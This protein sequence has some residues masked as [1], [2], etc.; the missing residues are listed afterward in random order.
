ME[1]RDSS[2]EITFGH[3]AR[4]LKNLYHSFLIRL[5]LLFQFI[6]KRWL[7]LLILILLGIGL[8]YLRDSR[9]TTKK[10]TT[11]ITQ[12]NYSGVPV[13]YDAVDQLAG[14]IDNRDIDFLKQHHLSRQGKP[15]LKKIKI[16]PVINLNDI[17]RRYTGSPGQESMAEELLKQASKEEKKVLSSPVFEPQYK[18]HKIEIVASNEADQ[19]TIEGVL[20]FLNENKTLQKS[21]E[22]YQKSLNS[23]IHEYELNIAQ[24]DSIFQR[25]GE[26]EN[27]ATSAQNIVVL[28]GTQRSLENMHQIL[29]EKGR[30]MENLEELRADKLSYDEPVALLNTPYWQ[31]DTRLFVKKIVQ[32]PILLI[33]LYFLFAI[34]A[35]GIRKGKRLAERN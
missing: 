23:K 27:A 29:R 22:V 7:V 28:P 13:I 4:G 18:V 2:D 8:G 32:F 5:Y 15:I 3:L 21:K 11:F 25:L 14:R 35:G 19:S 24:L 26:S 12:I 33:V 16:S 9:Q 34:L 30:M 31:M 10:K 1:V 17:L 20:N 6:I